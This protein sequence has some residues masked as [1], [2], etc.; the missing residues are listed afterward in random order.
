MGERSR[1]LGAAL[2]GAA[3]GGIAGYLYL[4]SSGRRFLEQLEPKLDDF[5]TEL[6]RW[7]RT[8]GKAQVVVSEAW[9]SLT[10]VASSDERQHV[11][12]WT[13]QGQRSPF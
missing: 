9:R 6:R 10:D 2:L 13:P 8:L 12:N 7:R 5:A 4:T 3:I 11:R 1:L